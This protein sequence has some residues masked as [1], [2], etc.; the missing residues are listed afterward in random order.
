MPHKTLC[1]IIGRLFQYFRI[2]FSGLTVPTAENIFLL[3][4]AMIVVEAVPSIRMLYI[5]HVNKR[6]FKTELAT[7]MVHSVM[8]QLH[9]VSHV[10]LLFDSWYTKKNLTCIIDEYESK[11]LWAE[12]LLVT[13][14]L[15]SA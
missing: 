10:F 9:T 4:L 5:S 13:S 15:Y 1:Y 11:L 2:Y 12:N 3:I 7:D 8:P 14:L 6:N